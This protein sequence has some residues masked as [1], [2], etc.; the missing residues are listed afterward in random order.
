MNRMLLLITM[1]PLIALAQDQKTLSSIA[2]D[3][4][5]TEQIIQELGPADKCSGLMFASQVLMQRGDLESADRF[6]IKAEVIAEAEG[7]KN[8]SLIGRCT[9]LQ[10]ASAEA[11]G[12]IDEARVQFGHAV[13]SF[14]KARQ[15]DGLLEASTRMAVLE[16]RR[17]R[18]PAAIETLAFLQQ[19]ALAGGNQKVFA[20]ASAQKSRLHSILKQLPE[21]KAAFAI[22]NSF[23][24]P[25]GTPADIARLDMLEAGVLGLEEN[26]PGAVRLLEKSFKFYSTNRNPVQAANCRFN[27]GLI[28]AGQG[29][30]VDSNKLLVEAAFYYAQSG[31]PTGTANAIGS[32]AGNYLT[33]KNL[34]VAEAML[35]QAAAMH[36]LGGN[37]MRAA[38]DQIMLGALS[39]QRGNKAESEIHFEKAT[40]L[41]K[42]CG[43]E[44]E[45]P[46]RSKAVRESIPMGA[47]K[48]EGP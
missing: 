29:Q 14:A 42:R 39:R 7:G 5:Q 30:F 16:E 28:L 1:V 26:F 43:L 12:K 15:Y 10:G 3:P 35:G 48:A 8:P 37:M 11:Q 34:P 6:L 17:G 31:S 20:E 23:L 46:K 21:A 40:G 33:M 24:G 36:E 38:E 22:A 4:G 13:A 27:A 19:E 45:G 9:L 41:F 2:A 47:S 18:L 25:S 44:E 32:Q